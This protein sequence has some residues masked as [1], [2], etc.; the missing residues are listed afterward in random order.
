MLQF[1]LASFL[2]ARGWK[3]NLKKRGKGTRRRIPLEQ[4]IME[5]P[6]KAKPAAT[7][8]SATIAFHTLQVGQCRN[9]T[10]P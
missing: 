10:F 8:E 6:Q 7:D 4:A 3:T 1:D 2:F 9:D 5:T